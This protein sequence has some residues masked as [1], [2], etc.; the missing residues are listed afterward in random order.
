MAFDDDGDDLAS[1]DSD[2]EEVQCSLN[3]VDA[4]PES[5]NQQEDEAD[6]AESEA[7]GSEDTE[8]SGTESDEDDDT[9]DEDDDD[10]YAMP[11]KKAE[12]KRP[13]LKLKKKG[14]ARNTSGESA[15]PLPLPKKKGAETPKAS[16]GAGGKKQAA[17]QD[18][19]VPQ[20][21]LKYSK[22][23]P[24]GSGGRRVTAAKVALPPGHDPTVFTSV[25]EYR[26]NPPSNAGAYYA[27][28]NIRA[29]STSTEIVRG[30]AILGSKKKA[31]P[32][33]FALVDPADD[34]AALQLL[35][36]EAPHLKKIAK[37]ARLQQAKAP[38]AEIFN[39]LGPDAQEVLNIASADAIL[40]APLMNPALAAK[41]QKP[42]GKGK[43]S[44]ALKLPPLLGSKNGTP[45]R[46]ET[47]ER[48]ERTEKGTT[49][50]ASATA[51]AA[52]AAAAVK[53]GPPIKA[54]PP[55][56]KRA[57]EDVKDAADADL[58]VL[59]KAESKRARKSLKDVVSE[60]IGFDLTGV[61]LHF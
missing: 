34:A 24:N 40:T 6:G 43:K 29:G 23:H 48:T 2:W 47:S 7:I 22:D 32:T 18:N 44:H 15:A 60:A 35:G 17:R 45:E 52:A 27:V 25:E 20:R 10:D 31:G 61:T 41:L 59:A 38:A 16:A 42:P 33:V 37:A 9:E 5:G 11:Q 53:P 55:K 39:A 12:Q 3:A 14:K 57:A 54:Q 1:N 46:S 28:S 19:E 26:S 36:A 21:V 8:S 13:S 56:R 50:A 58:I 51:V 4:P 30:V 49:E